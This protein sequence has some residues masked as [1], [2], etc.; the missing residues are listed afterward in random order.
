MSPH[1]LYTIFVLS[2]VWFQFHAE[3]SL[4]NASELTE[5]EEEEEEKEELYGLSTL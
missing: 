1:F 4:T 3:R 2:I 5:E